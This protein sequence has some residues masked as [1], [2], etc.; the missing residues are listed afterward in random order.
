MRKNSFRTDTERSVSRD[1]SLQPRAYDG[2][3][4]ETEVS[5]AS[6]LRVV[7]SAGTALALVFCAAARQI[8][9]SRE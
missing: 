1:G 9:T 2:A 4:C 7:T 3:D 5:G 6:R 8:L